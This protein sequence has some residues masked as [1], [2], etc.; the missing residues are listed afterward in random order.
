MLKKCSITKVVAKVMYWMMLKKQ[1]VLGNSDLIVLGSYALIYDSEWRSTVI[2]FIYY[3]TY[4]QERLTTG[5]Y[6]FYWNRSRRWHSLGYLCKCFI[7]FATR[8]TSYNFAKS[9]VGKKSQLAGYTYIH[10]LQEAIGE[11]NSLRHVI[12]VAKLWGDSKPKIGS[13]WPHVAYCIALPNTDLNKRRLLTFAD[14]I[15]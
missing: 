5:W 11:E 12:I 6:V 14:F 15:L 4:C 10:C 9:H 8:T 3:L 7:M 1:N 13:L 2:C